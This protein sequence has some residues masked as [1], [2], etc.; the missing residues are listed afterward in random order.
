MKQKKNYETEEKLLY[1]AVFF[2]LIF[3]TVLVT[4]AVYQILN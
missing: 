2:N 1:F 3:G 4:I